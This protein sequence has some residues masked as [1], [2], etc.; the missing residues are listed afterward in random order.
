MYVRSVAKTIERR[1]AEPRRFIQVVMGPRQVGKTTAVREVL[2]NISLPNLFFP[3]DAVLGVGFKV[4]GRSPHE[5]IK[6]DRL[7]RCARY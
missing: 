4:L 1:L 5:I 3:A 6:W 7:M 2:G